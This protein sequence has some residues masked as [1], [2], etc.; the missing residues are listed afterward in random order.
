MFN[1]F[2]VLFDV[3]CSYATQKSNF[4]LENTVR[5]TATSKQNNLI[6]LVLIITSM[7]SGKV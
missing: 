7:S 2:D 1:R 6:F 4:S 5:D 3:S